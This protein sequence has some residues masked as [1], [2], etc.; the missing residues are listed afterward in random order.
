MKIKRSTSRQTSKL[1]PPAPQFTNTSSPLRSNSLT[2]AV[3][4]EW[5]PPTFSALTKAASLPII[6]ESGVRINFGALF[7]RQRIVVVFIRH[8][9]CPLCQDYMSSVAS[10]TRSIPDLIVGR[11]SRGDVLDPEKEATNEKAVTEGV[12]LEPSSVKVVVISNGSYTMIGKYKQIFG[13]GALEVYTDPSL[14]VYAALG[15]GKDPTRGGRSK[16]AGAG[17]GS[18]GYVKHGLMGG[19]AMVFVRALKVGMP[20]WEKGGD[21][22]QLGG[23]FVFGPGLVCTYA[24]RMQTTK[25]HAPF[26][27]VLRAAGI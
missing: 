5:D 15:M 27:E 1:P 3:I 23:E 4:D 16:S 10:L 14:A 24:H 26:E 12:E 11:S 9:W 7:V 17:A 18:G 20:V 2:P 8:F 25:G 21:L 19:I 13:A 6:A 22:N